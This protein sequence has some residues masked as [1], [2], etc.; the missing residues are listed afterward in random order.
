M[1]STFCQIRNKQ[2]KCCQG[3]LKFAI[4]ENFRQIRSQRKLTISYFSSS[5]VS[6]TTDTTAGYVESN[7][8]KLSTIECRFCG[9]ALPTFAMYINHANKFHKPQIEYS[10]KKCTLIGQCFKIFKFCSKQAK[11]F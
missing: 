9:L 2:S 3:R 10:W 6:V 8:P 4:L 5:D 7:V 1:G 11:L